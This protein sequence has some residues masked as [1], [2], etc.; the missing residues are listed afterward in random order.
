MGDSVSAL[1]LLVLL[2]H[3]T[4][5]AQE[6]SEKISPAVFFSRNHNRV[7]EDKVTQDM[8]VTT[9]LELQNIVPIKSYRI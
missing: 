7:T 6:V 5:S 2:V 9:H 1:I 3:L 4:S 8:G